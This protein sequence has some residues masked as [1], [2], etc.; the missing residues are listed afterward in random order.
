MNYPISLADVYL[1]LGKFT[2][3]TADGSIRPS[4]DPAKWNNDVTDEILNVITHAGLTPSEADV[5]QLYQAIAHMIANAAVTGFKAL[6]YLDAGQ[7]IE[8]DGAGNARVKLNGIT[9]LR[10]AA[11]L[12]LNLSAANQWAAPQSPF[13]GVP[14]T[15]ASTVAWDVNVHGQF[16]K[17][18]TTAARTIGAPTNMVANTFFG[19]EVVTGGYT[20][21]WAAVFDWGAA[22]TPAG[23]TGTCTFIGWYNGT[24]MHIVP[25]HLGGV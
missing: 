7:G 13:V 5:T 22:G 1:H 12:S 15:D 6:A 17:L 2:D 8:P 10:A 11:G 23:L 16:A 9:L 19:L 3:G 24:K 18:T 4:R 21:S 25:F 14:M 20:P